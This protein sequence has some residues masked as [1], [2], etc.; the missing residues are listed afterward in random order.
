MKMQEYTGNVKDFGLTFTI[1]DSKGKEV[2]L[3]QFGAEIEV[4][5]DNKQRYIYEVA[6]YKLN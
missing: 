1:T 4:T 2:N 6:N 5:N 3:I